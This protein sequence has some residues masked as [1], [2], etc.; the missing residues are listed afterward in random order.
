M[1]WKQMMQ[2]SY[3]WDAK[4]VVRM[5]TSMICTMKGLQDKLGDLG[6]KLKKHEMGRAIDHMKMARSMVNGINEKMEDDKT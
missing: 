2:E 1:A 4:D 3:V 6:E 5:I